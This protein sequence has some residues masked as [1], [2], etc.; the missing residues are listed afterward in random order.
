MTATPSTVSAISALLKTLYSP[1]AVEDL[2][3]TESPLLAMVK[4]DEGFAGYD[5]KELL[6][7][8][9]IKGVGNIFAT[10]QGHILGTDDVNF[11][12]TRVKTYALAQITG[13]AIEASRAGDR[14][15]FVSVLK[16]QND[17]AAHAIGQTLSHQIYRN[18]YGARGT[19]GTSG[20][21]TGEHYV[22]LTN[23]DDVSLYEVGMYLKAGTTD[24]STLASATA[25]KI[26]DVDRDNGWLYMENHVYDTLAWRDGMY[27][28]RDSDTD[29]TAG[30]G[31]SGL[32]MSGLED[33]VP[34][35]AP[36]ATAFFGVD[37]TA[38]TSRLGGIRYNGASY[39]V[40]EALISAAHRA[41]RD[42]VAPTHVFMPYANF[43][44]L[45]NL[46]GSKVQYTTGEAFKNPQIGFEGVKLVGPKGPIQV[47]P[48]AFC[49]TNV[50]WMLTLP[51]WT[52]RSLNKAPHILDLDNQNLLRV[53]D[54]DSYEIRWGAYYQLGCSAPGKNVR[55]ALA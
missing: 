33:W 16:R 18:K 9:D 47:Y 50:A 10:A 1:D 53:S 38:D 51:T 11:T 21:A 54:S 5:F 26:T 23:A 27:L 15:A 32:C 22:K 45:V 28:Y 29:A 37:R 44:E 12:L 52:L 25:D 17:S 30:A 48:D 41:G 55:V 2:T 20:V 49:Q 7:Y 19:I 3:L 35:S 46:L 39:N 6:E 13:E 4:K 24:G 40:A 34:S 36:G 14:A 42:G 43:A 31:S 8:G